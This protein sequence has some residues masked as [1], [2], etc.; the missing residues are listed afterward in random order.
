MSKPDRGTKISGYVSDKTLDKLKTI[1]GD[2]ESTVEAIV[3][4]AARD[5]AKNYL[6]GMKMPSLRLDARKHRKK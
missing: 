2:R 1:A 5:F 4:W 3:E 6:P